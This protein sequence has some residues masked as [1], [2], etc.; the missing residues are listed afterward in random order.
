MRARVL[1]GK[2]TGAADYVLALR[3]RLRGLAEWMRGADALL[4]PCLPFAACRLEDVDETAT[5]LAAFTRAGNYVNASGL[6]LPAS[7][8]ADGLPVGVQLG[9]PHG[10]AALGRI[11]MAFQAATDWHLRRPD[12]GAVGL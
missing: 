12:L 7:F 9:R 8:T 3:P 2:A 4:T 6:A 5:P 1:A 10:E 11:G